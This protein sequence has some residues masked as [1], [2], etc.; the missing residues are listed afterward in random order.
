MSSPLFAPKC[1][2]LFLHIAGFPRGLY[3]FHSLTFGFRQ[4]TPSFNGGV[5][6]RGCFL[7][8]ANG[9]QSHGWYSFL[10]YRCVIK[11]SNCVSQR[12]Y[13]L[14]LRTFTI[15]A[16]MVRS[17]VRLA[18]ANL[19]QPDQDQPLNRLCVLEVVPPPGRK[20]LAPEKVKYKTKND[21]TVS[22]LRSI[23]GCAKREREMK[24][25][26][27]CRGFHPCMLSGQIWRP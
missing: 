8:R 6:Y 18:A 12:W 23:N 24:E 20:A 22:I 7:G 4:C 2:C 27:P 13:H 16:S 15:L 9:I 1:P 19:P 21:T 5:Q 26:C 25:C 11:G 14:C 17:Q 10:L 3:A